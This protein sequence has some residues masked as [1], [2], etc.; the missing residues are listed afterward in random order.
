MVMLAKVS[1]IIEH[2]ADEPDDKE[3]ENPG[4]VKQ[5]TGCPKIFLNFRVQKIVVQTEFKIACSTLIILMATI[6]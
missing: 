1:R 2:E 6:C 4:G 5:S 3:T